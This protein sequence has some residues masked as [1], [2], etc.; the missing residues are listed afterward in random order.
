[1]YLNSTCDVNLLLKLSIIFKE[2]R[3]IVLCTF[4]VPQRANKALIIRI[5]YIFFILQFG[6]INLNIVWHSFNNHEGYRLIQHNMVVHNH[7]HL[8]WLLS[9]LYIICSVWWLDGINEE[10]VWIEKVILLL[11]DDRSSQYVVTIEQSK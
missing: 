9:I 4:K 6:L 1:M 8:W 2:W 3:V 11:N 10:F 7:P 5:N